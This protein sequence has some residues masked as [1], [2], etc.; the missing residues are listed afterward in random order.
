MHSVKEDLLQFA[1]Q[2]KLL[3]PGPLYSISGKEIS[4]IKQG[5]LNRDSGPDFFNARIRVNNIILAGNI[6]VHVKTS[7]WLKHNHQTDKSYDNIILHLVY[8]N[9]AEIEQNTEYNVEVVELKK[10]LPEHLLKGYQSLINS[11]QRLACNAQLAAVN[12][13]TFT[14]WMQRMLIERMETK[15][16]W[17]EK[18]FESFEGN[19]AQTFYTVLLRNFGFKVN[20]LPFEILS[21]HLPVNLLVKHSD[22]LLQLEALLLGTAGL[23]DKQFEHPYV[24]N[25]QNEFSYLKNKYQIIPMSGELFKFSRLR[26][27]NFPTLRLA[28]FAQLI[29]FR[30]QLIQSPQAYM[31]AKH[32]IKLLDIQPANYWQHHYNLNGSKNERSLCFGKNSKENIVI[33][34]FAV[35]FFF[36]SRKTGLEEFRDLSLVLLEECS[37]EQN[38]K[39]K[40]FSEKKQLLKSA[41][42]SQAAIHLHDNYCV[43]K[44]CLRCGIAAAVLN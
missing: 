22:N 8:Q 17:I 39:T 12:E 43:K 26:P 7:D 38:T 21:K 35:F 44:N 6:E 32:L 20:A 37:F 34:T 2:H 25:L 10:L 40:L 36:Y 31:N 18:L 33:N 4:I 41:A 19:Y 28:Q 29:H 24:L 3:K 23:L 42:D 5:E 16:A 27:A 11:G 9:D 1:W 15:I 30:P 14:S 13:I